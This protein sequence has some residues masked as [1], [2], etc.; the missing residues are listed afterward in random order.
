M[1]V[2]ERAI[3][4]FLDDVASPAVAP[5][6]GATAA[7]TGAMAAALCE[8]VCV[9][10]AD[11]SPALVA[12]REDL[13]A[14]RARLLSLADADAAAVDAVAGVATPDEAALVRLTMVPLRVAESA[15]DVA[16]DAVVVAEEGTS[17]ARTDAVVGASLA[18]AAV[19]AGASMVRANLDAADGAVDEAWARAVR[20]R[21]AAAEREA[22]AALGR[23]DGA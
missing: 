8:M 3:G 6:A 4:A 12:A 17:S 22:D 9:H 5:S 11:A 15:R 7:V 23:L 13:A 2:A 1:T 20:E 19:A 14:R 10:T 21:L 18:R 16:E